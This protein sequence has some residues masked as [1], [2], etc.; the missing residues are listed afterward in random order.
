MTKPFLP[1]SISVMVLFISLVNPSLADTEQQV[2]QDYAYL[3]RLY[4]H[5]HANP[6]LSFREE[7]TAQRLA[8]ELRQTGYE[9]A[10][11][12]GG[13]GLVAVLRNGEG[14]VLMLRTDMDALPV[15]EQTGLPYSSK[16]T[17]KNDVGNI[18]PVMHACGHDIHMTVLVGTARQMVKSQSE[19]SGTL[20]LVAEPAEEHGAGAR[21]MLADGLFTRF[22]RPNY[23][24]AF[25]ASAEL[26]AGMLGYAAG[27]TTANVDSVDIQVRGIGGHGAYPHKTKD[28]IVIAAEIVMALQTIVSREISP[29]KSAVITVGSI[30]GGSKHNVIGNKV[31]LQLT[32]RSYSDETRDYLLKRIRE[33][34]ENIARSAGLAE[35]LLPIIRIKKEFTPSGYNNPELT[36]QASDNLKTLLGDKQ[37]IE[38][39]PVMAG[40]DFSRY[41]REEPKIPSLM[42]WLGAVDPAVYAAS[43]RDGTN[44]PSLHSS[45]FSPLPKETITTGVFSMTE[46]A[47]M[48]L[49]TEKP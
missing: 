27:Y 29:L 16:A 25:H 34:S 49:K 21:L 17:A 12:V 41:G 28:P 33:I 11:K 48:L 46:T 36:K 30:H 22:P 6:E 20:I 39:P 23:N 35:D 4:K 3:E 26:P 42:M 38:V 7:K 31:D 2:A 13:Y 24:F 44:L 14:S 40:E 47:L 8:K 10:E 43:K 1:Q 9:V 45:K 5:L 32:V 19:W 15:L 37:V 18:T